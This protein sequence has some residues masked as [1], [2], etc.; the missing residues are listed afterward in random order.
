MGVSYSKFI[1]KEVYMI[2]LFNIIWFIFFGWWQAITFFFLSI[3]FSITIIGIPIGKA[4]FNFSKLS[5]FPYGKAIVRESFIK[6]KVS[7]IRKIGGLILN[8]IWIPIG[9]IFSIMFIFSGIMVFFTIIGIPVGIVYVRMGKFSIFPI[10]CKVVGKDDVM[11]K[12]IF[13]RIK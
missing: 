11:A 9:I 10:G 12:K 1:S 3:L 5:A 4:C 6:D 7:I 13:D 2:T 8:I